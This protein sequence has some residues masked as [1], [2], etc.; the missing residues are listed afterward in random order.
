MSRPGRTHRPDVGDAY[1]APEHGHGKRRGQIPCRPSTPDGAAAPPPAALPGRLRL[2]PLPAFWSDF[3]PKGPA[4][5]SQR[6]ADDLDAYTGSDASARLHLAVASSK[7][8]K[9]SPARADP[10][11]SSDVNTLAA[12][13]D[14]LP[15][16][17]RS[18]S[19]NG[20]AGRAALR[21]AETT[22]GPRT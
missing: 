5:T 4:V 21:P 11:V 6:R 10:A 14:I 17:P 19:G 7:L 13:A 9:E 3:K 20:G 18:G 16:S 22:L 2:P 1:G 8:I 12:P 15:P